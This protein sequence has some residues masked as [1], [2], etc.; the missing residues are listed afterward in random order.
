MVS[1]ENGDID[2]TLGYSIWV[3]AKK[4]GPLDFLRE[5]IDDGWEQV[6]L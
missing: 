3:G 6:D 4:K 5:I 2:G 1:M